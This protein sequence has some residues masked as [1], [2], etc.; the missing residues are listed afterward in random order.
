MSHTKDGF[1]WDEN[2]QPFLELLREELTRE[3]MPLLQQAREYRVERTR[4][5]FRKGATQATE[6]TSQAIQNHVPAVFSELT[7]HQDAPEPA[8]NLATAELISHRVIDVELGGR[9]WRVVLELSVD[10]AVGEWLEISDQ[11][12]QRVPEDG[13]TT[14]RV[15]GLRL[16]LVHPFMQRFCGT[17]CEEIEPLLRIAAALGLAEVA[18]RDTGAKKAGAVRRNVNE[19]LR[20]AFSRT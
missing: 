1:Q 8:P 13:D 4:D 2:E 19:L 9:P 15:V 18:A 20:N 14:R 17:D 16:S 10:P 11:I 6:R 3:E 12:A 7:S 5:D